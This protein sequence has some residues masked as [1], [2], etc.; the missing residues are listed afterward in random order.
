MIRRIGEENMNLIKYDE[1]QFLYEW[2]TKNTSQLLREK[3]LSQKNNRVETYWEMCGG[4]EDICEYDFS[5]LRDFQ[6]MLAGNLKEEYF[7]ELILPLA[8]ATFI[9]HDELRDK[10]DKRDDV[11]NEEFL[12]PDF[13]YVF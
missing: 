11:Q 13:V 2:F 12:I 3:F 6:R 10:E 1:R 5:T 8:V 9:A 7:R 4:N